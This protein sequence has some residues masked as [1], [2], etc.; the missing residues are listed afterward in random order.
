MLKPQD[1]VVSIK[2]LQGRDG[3]PAPTY[4]TLAMALRMSSSEVH[5]AVGRCLEVGLLRK[6]GD[7]GRTMPVPVAAAMEEFLLH[8]LK[9][10]WPAK[11]GPMTRGVATGSSCESVSR[12]LD[13]SEPGVP[14]VWPHPEGTLRGEAV[15]PLYPRAV[16]ACKEDPILHEWLA[17]LD[18]LRLKTGREAALAGAAIHNRL[19]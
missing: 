7:A 1:I 16:E 9:F 15:D 5:A 12:L 4:A 10:I 17:L 19:A 2:L 8:G 14:L 11:R 18:I 3:G 6:P 13:V